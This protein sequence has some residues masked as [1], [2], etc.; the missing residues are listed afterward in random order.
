RRLRLEIVHDEFARGER[1]PA[2]RA[3][4]ANQHDLIGGRELADARNDE[5][6]EDIP[7]RLRV[8]DDLRER[9]LGHSRVVLE[10]EL[11]YCRLAVDVAYRADEHGHRTDA[12]IAAAQRRKLARDVE[13]IG[14]YAHRHRT[15]TRFIHR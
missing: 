14:L 11:S 12:R 10:R 4:D 3:R 6:V 13:V 5:R 8:G 7:P 15:T 1:I 2:M 9:L